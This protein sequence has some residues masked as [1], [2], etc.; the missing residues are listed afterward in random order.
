LPWVIEN[1]SSLV[2]IAVSR[3]CR[4]L[5]TLGIEPDIIVSIDPHPISFDVSREMLEFP[6]ALLVNE[7][8]VTP[9]LLGNWRGKCAYLNAALPWSNR[10]E[11]DNIHGAGPTVTNSALELAAEMGFSQILLLGVDLCY[12]QEGHSHASGSNERSVGAALGS[13]GLCVRTNVGRSAETDNAFRIAIGNLERQA[14]AI[15]QRGA[16]LIN[17]SGSA[18]AINHVD[19]VELSTLTLTPLLVSARQTIDQAYAQAATRSPS[20]HYQVVQEDLWIGKTHLRAL[21]RM[22]SIAI[23][24]YDQLQADLSPKRRKRYGDTLDH[25]EARLSSPKHETYARLAKIFGMAQFVRLLQPDDAQSWNCDEFVAAGKGFYAAYR[26]GADELLRVI[27]A[28]LDRHEVRVEELSPTPD[29]SLLCDRW[30][31]D[32]QPGRALIWCDAHGVTPATADGDTATRLKALTEAYEALLRNE[33][34]AHLRR[35]KQNSGLTGI[36]G[37]ALEF[38]ANADDAGLER[39]AAGLDD[40]PDPAALPLAALSKGLSAELAGDVERAIAHYGSIDTGPAVEQALMRLAVIALGQEDYAHALVAL[41]HL[42]TLSR[43]YLPKLADLLRMTGQTQRA[44]DVYTDYLTACPDDLAAMTKLGL[45]Y[46]SLGITDSAQWIFN[47]VGLHSA[48]RNKVR[49]P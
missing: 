32:R 13:I 15:S 5:L 20:S 26:Y 39:L 12:S 40:H 45:L 33:D 22:A 27:D 41:E 8:H 24:L 7:N 19:Y 48:D 3:I 49:S 37:K 25:L 43:A 29:W 4:Q 31:K 9:L 18:A 30:S 35:C 6:H 34:T 23:K 28:A 47:H 17:P 44:I 16:R 11:V 42:A 46:Q 10:Y 21:K 2:L 36:V 38:F 14:A 1:R